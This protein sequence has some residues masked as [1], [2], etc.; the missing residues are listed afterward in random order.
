MSDILDAIDNLPDISFIDDLTLQDMQNLLIKAYQDK[1][2]ELT[3]QTIHL[4]KADPNRIILLANAQYYYQGLQQIDKAGKMNYLKYS[5]GDYLRHVAA[6]KNT[7]EL[8]PQKATVSVKWAL[9]EARAAATAIPEGT[10]V[11]ADWETFFET[12]E[13]N[14][15]PVGETEIIITMACTETGSAA[16]DFAPGEISEMVDP[17]PFIESVSNTTTSAGG[18]DDETDQSLAERAYL[19]PSAYST[20]GTE[21]SYVYHAKTYDPKIGDVVPT[22]PSPGVSDIRFIMDDGSLPTSGEIEGLKAYLTD[23]ARKGLTDHIEVGAPEVVNYSI[24]ATYYINKS[25]QSSAAAIQ[26][27]AEEAL[28]EYQAWQS[29]RIGRDINPDELLSLL[30][31]AGVK[32]VAITSPAYQTL[33]NGQVAKCTAAALTYGGIEND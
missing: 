1:Y 31:Q 33:G 2:K 4:K 8:E 26:E 3:G 5:Y 20:T 23:R 29:G 9:A 7:D 25:D 24:A 17:L 10:R 18:T 27:A 11:T 30:K 14:E 22:S 12:T 16:N 21:D 32:R 13:Y 15:I 28:E 19:A 6:F